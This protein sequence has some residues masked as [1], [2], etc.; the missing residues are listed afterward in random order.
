M[1]VLLA[2]SDEIA[3]GTP[4]SDGR[5]WRQ[6]ASDE[7]DLD[8]ARTHWLGILQSEQYEQLLR[9]S[10]VHFYLTVPFV[11]SWS[12]L[13]AM[14]AGCSIVASRT[15]PVIEVM[16]HERSGLLVDFWNE[17]EQVAALHRCLNEPE[18]RQ[19]CADGA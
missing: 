7:L 8:P 10:D 14:A 11:L 16:E 15:A 19:R 9:C 18:L 1:H 4:R 5:T 12:L 17:D 2:G 6:W 3:Y 13:E